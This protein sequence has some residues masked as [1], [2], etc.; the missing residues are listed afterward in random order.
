[1]P[2]HGGR[3]SPLTNKA[4]PHQTEHEGGIHAPFNSPRPSVA[5]GDAGA[6]YGSSGGKRFPFPVDLLGL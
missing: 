3:A 6:G 4:T 2:A 5:I 1:M